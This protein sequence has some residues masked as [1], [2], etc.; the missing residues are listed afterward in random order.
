MLDPGHG[1]KDD[2]T[3]NGRSGLQEKNVALDVA[4]R[5]GAQL[6]AA[7]YRVVFT[8][9]NDTFVPLPDRP[10]VATHEK[11]D[12]F[13]SIH[14]NA[15][16]NAA[17]SGNE[18]YILTPQNQES[19]DGGGAGSRELVPTLLPGNRLDEWNAVLG[20][21]MHRMLVQ[22]M[23]SF[24]R[25]LKR[26]RFVV[27]RDLNCPGILVEGGYLSNNVEAGKIATPEWREQL[28]TAIVAGIASYREALEVG[29]K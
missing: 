15:I 20:Y 8:R 29:K 12:L 28:A 10:A 24:D 6:T 16:D 7:G 19:T 4:K 27:L 21:R 23:K 26:A 3:H 13:V 25:G 22:Q 18:T 5:V 2:G 11:A 9:S 1:G 14:F 17:V